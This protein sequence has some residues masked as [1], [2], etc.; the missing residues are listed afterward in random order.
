MIEREKG[1]EVATGPTL[2]KGI[3]TTSQVYANKFKQIWKIEIRKNTK[4]FIN[5][6]VWSYTITEPALDLRD[7][8]VSAHGQTLGR[9]VTVHDLDKCGERAYS[10]AANAV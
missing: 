1:P 5:L 8:A 4:F 9:W 3:K 7:T 10:L 6:L 2:R